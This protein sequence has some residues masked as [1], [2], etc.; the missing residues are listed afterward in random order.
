[1][2]VNEGAQYQQENK[3]V[4]VYLS[5]PVTDTFFSNLANH[6]VLR[7][8]T[9]HTDVCMGRVS[10]SHN[11]QSSE[12]VRITEAQRLH[13]FMWRKGGKKTFALKEESL[14]LQHCK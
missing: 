5:A 13:F 1:M 4:C 11:S 7:Y 6:E 9:K 3:C 8:Q 12:V 2:E 14:S 10:T